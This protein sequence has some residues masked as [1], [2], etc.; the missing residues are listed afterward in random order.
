[1]ELSVDD[2]GRGLHLEEDRLPVGGGERDVDDVTVVGRSGASLGRTGDAFDGLVGDE[3][4][5]VCPPEFSHRIP[6]RVAESSIGS[7]DVP[8]RVEVIDDGVTGFIVDNLNEAVEAV[9]KIPNLNR[10]R[11]RQIFEERFSASRMA[12]D[13]VAI[14][15]QL[16]NQSFLKREFRDLSSIIANL[17]KP[18]MQDFLSGDIDTGMAPA[19][20]VGQ[21]VMADKRHPD[22]SALNPSNQS[23]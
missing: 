14:Y 1:V 6:G 4:G 11:C 9:T 17:P 16:L 22:E 13:Y 19:E 15:Q 8:V 18:E 7:E 21:T 23:P 20:P 12:C 2:Q 5:D 10:K 3:A